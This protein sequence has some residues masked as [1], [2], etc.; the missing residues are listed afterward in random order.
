MYKR[1]LV[2]DAVAAL[3][4]GLDAAPAKGQ[5]GRS[6]ARRLLTRASRHVLL[7]FG[8]FGHA[9]AAI[10]TVA[11]LT[12][13]DDYLERVHDG[14]ALSADDAR[15]VAEVVKAALVTGKPLRRPLGV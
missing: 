12:L 6:I 10:R 1:Q 2:D 13:L 8:V 9:R 3:A 7:A 11:T 15:A 5:L 4:D 14:S